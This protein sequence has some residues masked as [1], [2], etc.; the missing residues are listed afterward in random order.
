MNTS[1][2]KTLRAAI[3]ESGLS[4]RKL[5]IDSGVDPRSI[6]R[7]MAKTNTLRLD[8]AGKLCEY[9]GLELQDRKGK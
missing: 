2:E 1:I 4:F 9:L 8:A 6:S 3:K 5:S 7:F